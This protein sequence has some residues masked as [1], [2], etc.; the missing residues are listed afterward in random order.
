M[1]VVFLGSWDQGVRLHFALSFPSLSAEPKFRPVQGLVTTRRDDCGKAENSEPSQKTLPKP[2]MHSRLRM[3]PPALPRVQFRPKLQTLRVQLCCVPLRQSS[4][5]DAFVASSVIQLAP[6]IA[7]RCSHCSRGRVLSITDSHFR[8][9]LV[10]EC[11]ALFVTPENGS[12]SKKL[13]I[14]SDSKDF[15]PKP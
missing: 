14:Y 3:K 4:S 9:L 2:E 7:S 12:C 15:N 11:S 10:W 6:S 8:I 13:P 5:S 1:K